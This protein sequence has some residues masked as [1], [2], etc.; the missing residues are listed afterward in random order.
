MAYAN[1]NNNKIYGCKKGT[2]TYYHEE[3]HLKYE[4]TSNGRTIRIYQEL[5]KDMLLKFVAIWLIFPNSVIKLLIF[6][7]LLF[8][9][10]STIKEE[11]DCW[12][13]AR[14]KM[15]VMRDDRISKRKKQ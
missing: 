5:S 15:K 2:K 12:K 4:D 10:F 11:L 13:Y 7:C 8:S 14:N 6:G 3:A 1:L 9:I